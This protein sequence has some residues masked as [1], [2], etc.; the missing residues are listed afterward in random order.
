VQAVVLPCLL[1]VLTEKTTLVLALCASTFEMALLA[2]APAF[3]SSV[4]YLAVTIGALGSM[5]FPIISALKSVNAHEGEQG[6]VQ[7]RPFQK[8]QSPLV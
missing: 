3:S 6:K 5:A 2:T 4:V 1:R 7:A 8:C